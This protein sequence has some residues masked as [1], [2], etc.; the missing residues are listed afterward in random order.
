MELE[1]G[2]VRDWYNNS[3]RTNMSIFYGLWEQDRMGWNEVN[4]VRAGEAG[5]SW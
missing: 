3:T 1:E 2:R 5:N 4:D